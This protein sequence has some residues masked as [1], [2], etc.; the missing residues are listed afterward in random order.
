VKDSSH[1]GNEEEGANQDDE[2]ADDED[3]VSTQR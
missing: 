1:Q 2:E 3:F